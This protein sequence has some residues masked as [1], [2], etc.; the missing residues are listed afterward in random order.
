MRPTRPCI[1]AHRHMVVSG[2]YWASLA[3]HQI[4]ESGGNAVDAGVAVGLAINVLESEM[5]GFGGV[6]P[7]LIRLAKDGR[8]LTFVGVGPWPKA[9]SAEYFRTN[10]G[11]RVPKGILNTVVP[12]APDIWLTAL[13]QFG[14]MRFAEVAEAAIRFARNGFPMYPLMAEVLKLHL[15]EYRE[16]PTTAAIFC[17]NGQVPKVGERFLQTELAVTLQYLADEE[18]SAKGSREL[19]I[20][21]ARRAFYEG[22][23]ARAIIGQQEELGGLMTMRDL[24]EFRA[25]LVPATSGRFREYEL[26][27]C[28]PWSQ[29][30]MIL[31]AAQM[32]AGFPLEAMGHNSTR[33]IHTVAEALKLAAAD[34]EAYFGDPSHI[35]VPLDRILGSAFTADRAEQIGELATPAMPAPGRIE[36]YRIRPWQP[37]PTSL[38]AAGLDALETSYFCV[39]DAEGNVFSATPSDPTISGVVVPGTGITTSMWGSRG[40]THEDHPARV[41]AGWRPRMSANPLLAVVPGKRIIPV[42]S[43]GSEVLGQA[44]LQVLLNMAVFGMDPQS[45][46]EAPRFASYSWPASAIPHV[47][48]PGQLNLEGALDPSLGTELQDLGHLVEWWPERTWRAGS[49][50]TI[51]SDVGEGVLQGG[52][53]PRRTAYAIGW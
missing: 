16:W 22:D 34:R 43:P 3:G 31:Q 28:G 15:P 45:A 9:L 17:P 40:H 41:G 21:A 48:R 8:A 13:E 36:G 38:P 27:G 49:V 25:E 5:T 12:A 29:G 4:L 20:D 10:H 42:G 14:T 47:Y 7:T 24:A 11:G 50:C 30:P 37:D 39:V 44:Q 26:Y 46:V 33:Y 6:A 19:G 52:A 23:V 1:M 53:D 2:H 18:V 35:D 51:R 32:L